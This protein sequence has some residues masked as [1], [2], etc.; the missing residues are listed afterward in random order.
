M[1]MSPGERTTL[2]NTAEVLEEMA[3][4]FRYIDDANIPE[5]AAHSI[6][7]HARNQIAIR[8]EEL[9][10]EWGF[11]SMAVCFPVE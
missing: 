3:K 10:A 5:E 2:L 11:D 6:V 1:K 8:M 4:N 9:A 7:S